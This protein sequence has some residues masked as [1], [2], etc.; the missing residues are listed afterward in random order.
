VLWCSVYQVGRYLLPKPFNR[1][2][3]VTK[4]STL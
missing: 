4:P 2:R 1:Y 3:A